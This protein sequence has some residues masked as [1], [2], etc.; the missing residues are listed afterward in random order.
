MHLSE[1][2]VESLEEVGLPDTLQDSSHMGK[3]RKNREMDI[4][5]RGVTMSKTQRRKQLSGSLVTTD[6]R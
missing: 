1:E 2:L 3:G 5:G 6:Q 4:L